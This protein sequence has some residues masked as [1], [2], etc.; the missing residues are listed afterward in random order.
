MVAKVPVN[1]GCS[2]NQAAVSIPS[3][4]WLTI[5]GERHRIRNVPRTLWNTTW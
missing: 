2:R 3:E 1:Q 5:G 4:T